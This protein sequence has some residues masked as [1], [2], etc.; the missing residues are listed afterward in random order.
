MEVLTSLSA[1]SEK[2]STIQNQNKKI[3]KQL[4]RMEKRGKDDNEELLDLLKVKNKKEDTKEYKGFEQIYK[5]V[6]SCF[7]DKKLYFNLLISLTKHLLQ[8]PRNLSYSTKCFQHVVFK[9]PTFL[10][11]H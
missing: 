11:F 3:M 5:F 9:A 6:Y 2:I 7:E 1:A 8:K 4:M 10:L